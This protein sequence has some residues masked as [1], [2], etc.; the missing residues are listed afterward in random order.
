MLDVTAAAALF[1]IVVAST[2]GPQ[3]LAKQKPW[4]VTDQGDAFLVVG[5]PYTQGKLLRYVKCHVFFAKADAEVLGIGCD[6]RQILSRAEESD[7]RRTMTPAQFDAVFG[8]A[9]EWERDGVRDAILALYG[10]VVN[11]PAD[12]LAYAKI[13]LQTTS[14]GT[15]MA[16]GLLTAEERGGVWHIARVHE[17][18]DVLTFSRT[19]GKVLT[20]AL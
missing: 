12:A 19:S 13:L 8:E 4:Q 2:N 1:A 10:G 16:Q 17:R 14:R 18:T 20:S 11:T 5:T 15:T 9:F 6:G 7:W 3:C